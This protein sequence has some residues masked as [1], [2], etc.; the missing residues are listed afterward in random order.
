MSTPLP[1]AFRLFTVSFIL[2]YVTIFSSALSF[3]DYYEWICNLLVRNICIATAL[4]RSLSQL[5]VFG[6][7]TGLP[8]VRIITFIAHLSSLH[9]SLRKG[10]WILM[11]EGISS[12]PRASRRFTFV[13]VAI[14]IPASFR[15]LIGRLRHVVSY[16]CSASFGFFGHPCLHLHI[17]SFRGYDRT[18]IGKLLFM[19]GAPRHIFLNMAALFI[20]YLSSKSLLC[21]STLCLRKVRVLIL[22]RFSR[23]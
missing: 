16:C 10:Y 5:Q 23:S 2:K 9:G 1:S 21:S 4:R 12:S 6:F 17:P 19:L 7:P 18:F 15:F 3:N 11:V 22:S 14:L 13:Q 20:L 8:W